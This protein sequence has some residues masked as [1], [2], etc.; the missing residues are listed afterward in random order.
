MSYDSRTV[1][2][3]IIAVADSRRQSMDLMTLLKLVYFFS[4]ARSGDTRGAAF[5][6]RS[7]GVEVRPGYPGGVFCL[8]S[9]PRHL[10]TQEHSSVRSRNR[11]MGSRCNL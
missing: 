6:A 9:P 1:A 8:P 4:W 5:L 11:N 3:Q 2:N 10:R 7:E